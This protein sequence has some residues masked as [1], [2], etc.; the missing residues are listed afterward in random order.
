MFLLMLAL[1]VFAWGLHYKLS[2]YRSEATQCQSVAKLL[3]Q[4]ERPFAGTETERLLLRGLPGPVITSRASATSVAV[5][6]AAGDP[7]FLGG[8]AGFVE[9]EANQVAEPFRHHDPFDPRGPPAT[10]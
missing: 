8:H 10:V 3:S 4:K 5:L 7:A 2:L 6:P 1:A 9:R